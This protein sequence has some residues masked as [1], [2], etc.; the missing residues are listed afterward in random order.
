MGVKKMDPF[1]KTSLGKTL[2]IGILDTLIKN[3]G[4]STNQNLTADSQEEVFFNVDNYYIIEKTLF[5]EQIQYNSEM[6]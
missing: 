3:I 5:A 2:F 1:F 6:N 4:F